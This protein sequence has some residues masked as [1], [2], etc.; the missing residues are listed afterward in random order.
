MQQMYQLVPVLI[1]QWIVLLQQQ[2][3]IGVIWNSVSICWTPGIWFTAWFAWWYGR[4]KSFHLPETWVHIRYGV[5][6][7]IH[8]PFWREGAYCQKRTGGAQNRRG[9]RNV[10]ADSAGNVRW[11]GY[12][13]WQ[14]RYLVV[15]YS[16]LSAYPGIC[17]FLCIWRASGTCSL[18]PL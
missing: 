12:A 11:L 3:H 7:G 5:P 10:V 16:A 8:E 15:L 14:L 2:Y 17:L 18:C 9:V 4:E 13:V 1:Q 6:A